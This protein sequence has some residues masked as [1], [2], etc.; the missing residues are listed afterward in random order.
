MEVYK[1]Y[2]YLV[3]LM[4]RYQNHP[5][6]EIVV[7]ALHGQDIEIIELGLRLDW[8]EHKRGRTPM[9]RPRFVWTEKAKECIA[10]LD[11]WE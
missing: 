9:I 11:E 2:D 10:H 1:G 6:E 4:E 8:L 5:G 3:A 7:M